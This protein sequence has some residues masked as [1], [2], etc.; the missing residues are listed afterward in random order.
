ML[1][2]YPSVYN[3]IVMY[4]PYSGFAVYDGIFIYQLTW[5]K[6]IGVWKVKKYKLSV[7]CTP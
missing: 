4:Q 1:S 3:A 6:V 7:G 5:G 2:F